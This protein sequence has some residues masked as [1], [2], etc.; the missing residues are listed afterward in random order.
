[1]ALAKKGKVLINIAIDEIYLT[2]E[3]LREKMKKFC[4]VNGTFTIFPIR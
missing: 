2:M 4:L 1:M 3:R